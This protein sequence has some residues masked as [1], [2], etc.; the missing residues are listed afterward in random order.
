MVGACQRDKAI[1]FQFAR[2]CTSL[3]EGAFT[4]AFYDPPDKDVPRTCSY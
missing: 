4:Y 2:A 1:L 3:R